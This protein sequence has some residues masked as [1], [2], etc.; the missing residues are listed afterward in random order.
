TVLRLREQLLIGR[1]AGLLFGLAGARAG[2]DPLLLALEGPL[3][4]LLLALLLLQPLALLL[5]PAGVVA[6]IGDAAAAIEL[7]DPAGDIVE[8]VAVVGDGHDGAF[9]LL[10]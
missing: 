9:V 7:Q 4:G 2:G 5:E 10:E 8:E 3:A 6:L 1:D